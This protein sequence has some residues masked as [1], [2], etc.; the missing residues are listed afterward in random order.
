[1][2]DDEKKSLLALMIGDVEGSPYYPLFTSIQYGQF[3]MMAGGSVNNAV[4]SAAISASMVIG[5]DYTR[6]V[7]GDLQLSRNAGAN[8]L[9]A[10]DYL[11]K[12][13]KA[14]IPAKL[15]PW[16]GGNGKNKLLDYARC[17]CEE[18]YTRMAPA[19][20]EAYRELQRELKST[21]ADVMDNKSDISTLNAGQVAQQVEIEAIAGRVSVAEAEIDA[22]Q[23]GVGGIHVENS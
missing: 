5:S 14:T 22:L 11:I 15:M 13:S 21:E 7:I 16:I 8:Y 12:N 9:K 6:E 10:L 3:L 23:G 19:Y 4:Q 17:D 1:M 2:T 18:T 20:E